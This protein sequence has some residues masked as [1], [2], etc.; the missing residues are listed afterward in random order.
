MIHRRNYDTSGN[1]AFRTIVV[2]S[3]GG[4]IDIHTPYVGDSVLSFRSTKVGIDTIS[5]PTKSRNYKRK[6]MIVCTMGPKCWS[7]EMLGK[8]LDA[9]LNVARFNFSHGDHAGHA[10]VLARFRRVCESKNKITATMLDT[11]GPEIRTAMLRNHESIELVAGQ[12][13]IVQAVGDEYTIFEG[14]KTDVETRIGLS[15]AGLCKS[16]K[17][18]MRIL[19]ADGSIS[20]EVLD[21]LSE[22]ELRGRVLNT[23]K[24]GERKNCNLPGVKVDIPVL[25]VKDID[26]LQNF[27]CK[28]GVDFV[29]ASFVQSAEDV[30]FIR[31]VLD[32]AGGQGIRIISKIEN[33]AG[34]NN[35]DEILKYTDGVM[36]ARGDLGMEIP[37]E[38]VAL[39]QKL[40]I[41][42]SNIAGKFVI[43]ATQMLESMCGNPTPTRAEMTDVANA[44][45]DG[46]DAV[47]LSGETA[48][49]EFPAE[50]VH[51]MHRI[52]KNAEL[53]INYY[54]VY[55]FI[56]DFTP[57]PVGTVEAFVACAAKNAV[58]LNPGMILAF[59][60]G[61]KT[62]R[63]AAKY[64]PGV[65]VMV[66]TSNRQLA[67]QC[68][69]VFGLFAHVLD[70]PLVE[71][72]DLPALIEVA[73]AEAVNQYPPLCPMGAEVIVLGAT[74]VT[75]PN[76]SPSS[77]ELEALPERQM[78]FERAPGHLS[79]PAVDTS[80][81]TH[82]T[83]K[84]LSLRATSIS[85]DMVTNLHAPPRKTKIIVT[86]G[87]KCWSPE[88]ISAM[89]DAGMSVGKFNLK[90]QDRAFHAELLQRFQSIAAA[91]GVP[92]ACMLDTLGP[93]IRTGALTDHMPVTLTKDSLVTLV[94]DPNFVG[95]RNNK[96]SKV[97]ITYA[98]LAQTV[99]PGS[100]I[101]LAYG[102]MELIVQSVLSE[103]EVVAKVVNTS[104]LMEHTAVYMPGAF[105]D[106]PV[107]TEKDVADVR[108]GVNHGVTS[109]ALS[110]TQSAADVMAVRAILEEEGA[111]HVRVFAKIEN[112][113]GLK[114]V[115]EILMVSDGIVVARGDLGMDI[116]PEKVALAQKLLITKCNIAG[117]PC[118]VARH[119]LESMIS[120]QL[121]TRAEMTDV[122]NAVLDGA[123]CVMMGCETAAGDFP[124]MA[125]S[126]C[127]AICANAEQ[128]TNSYASFSFIRDFS[129]KPFNTMEAVTSSVCKICTDTGAALVVCVSDA[130]VAATGVAKYRPPVPVV[131][132]TT[133]ATTASDACHSYGLLPLVVP[134]LA[135]GVPALVA[136]AVEAATRVGACTAGCGPI[137]LVHGIGEPCGDEEPM[138]RVIANLSEL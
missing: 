22:T 86:I 82:Y 87:A 74:H 16:M 66:L 58:D 114:N 70:A 48:N 81:A 75:P 50:A 14:Y 78:Y 8:L 85:L 91:K 56:R 43:T 65:P 116:L 126:T 60:E 89:F 69:T 134:S 28:L 112:L 3:E 83:A 12:E 55:D 57:K 32:E 133:A 44:V 64:R 42:K 36:V 77:N 18:G 88:T 106:L 6:T 49:G 53:G 105:V 76:P 90:D 97:G 11:K 37:S 5:E 72:H 47:M 7:E 21:I 39:A 129:A 63:L 93:L 9:G 104:L 2:G 73:L 10:E 84:T 30:K 15:Y 20:I 117:K 138:L 17:A 67:R 62:M 79:V 119:L 124:V 13:I 80:L 1:M 40:L 4:A 125:V 111:E 127:A 92:P 27:G 137:V 26:D 59:S 128:A 38:K 132:V 46:T 24:L 29:A 45:F 68:S 51:T 52:C 108:F 101:L 131:V 118:V 100:R 123:S 95:Y 115:D 71:M 33:Q 41:T 25:T 120:N 107:L 103:T 136:A 121:P 31:R 35:F 94:A 122:A 110:F 130:G 113:A 54:Q 102:A 23:K 96:E 98:A 61:G 99:V 135:V 19:I 109:I 34:L